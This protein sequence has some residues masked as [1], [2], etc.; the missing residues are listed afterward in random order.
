MVVGRAQQLITRSRGMP[1]CR[2]A[3]DRLENPRKVEGC[4][5][6]PSARRS[7][8]HP[9]GRL[10]GPCPGPHQTRASGHPKCTVPYRRLPSTPQDSTLG[11]SRPNSREDPAT[12]LAGSSRAAREP[13]LGIRQVNW[14][15]TGSAD[16]LRT[17]CS[18]HPAG[19]PG[20]APQPHRCTWSRPPGPSWSR[21]PL[22]IRPRKADRCA[23]CTYAGRGSTADCRA[24]SCRTNA[25]GSSGLMTTPVGMPRSRRI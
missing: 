13:P 14:I 11:S 24:R 20:G 25:S 17:R 19:P 12:A 8:H 1:L 6:R 18:S 15:A 2:L 23:L 4:R 9:S 7:F 16:R 5:L 21:A 3:V 10:E 22:R